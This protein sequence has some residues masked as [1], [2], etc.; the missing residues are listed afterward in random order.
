MTGFGHS[1]G[2]EQREYS[3][4]EKQLATVYVT[5]LASEAITGTASVTVYKT[6]SFA[7]WKR[8][9]MTKPCSGTAQTPTL[10]K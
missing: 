2:K 10:V 9:W 4:F 3:L 8:N 5:L 6:Y 7:E 1:H